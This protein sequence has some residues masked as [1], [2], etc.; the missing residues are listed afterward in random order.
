MEDEALWLQDRIAQL[1]RLAATISDKRA[2]QVI[3][4]LIE[5]AEVR[6]KQLSE[7]RC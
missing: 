5:E 3:Q 4:A 7:P 6:L 1:R 2:L